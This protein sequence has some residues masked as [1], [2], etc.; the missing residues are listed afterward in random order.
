[1]GLLQ[2]SVFDYVPQHSVRLER[3]LPRG[4]D[5]DARRA[6]AVRPLDFVET[7]RTKEVWIF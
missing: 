5:D 1:M 7:L 3:Q 6:I 4:A 2:I